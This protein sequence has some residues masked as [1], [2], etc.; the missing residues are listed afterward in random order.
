MHRYY[1][2]KNQRAKQVQPLGVVMRARSPLLSMKLPSNK[3]KAKVYAAN[4]DR[5]RGSTLAVTLSNCLYL[6]MG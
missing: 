1:M 3:D 2:E 5:I 4:T 6:I